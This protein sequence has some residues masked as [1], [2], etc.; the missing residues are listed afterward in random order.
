MKKTSRIVETTD[1]NSDANFKVENVPVFVREVKH[2]NNEGMTTTTAAS[3]SETHSISRRYECIKVPTQTPHTFKE[4]AE[5]STELPFHE[6]NFVSRKELEERSDRLI[7]NAFIQTKKNI[8]RSVS[9]KE[10]TDS[11]TW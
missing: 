7:M 5:Q 3:T 4:I 2:K 6:L 11:G 8:N 1:N 10:I 9:H